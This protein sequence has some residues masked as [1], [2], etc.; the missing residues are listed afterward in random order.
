MPPKQPDLTDADNPEWTKADFARALPPEALP[1]EVLA[2]FPKTRR[3]GPNKR[4]AKMLVSLRL[5][6]EIV[7]RY[8]AT[9][10]GWQ[11]RINADLAEA[12]KHHARLK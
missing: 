1:P 5:D 8:R 10:E 12:S 2:A 6:P 3:R 4:P 11:A 7:E 9:G